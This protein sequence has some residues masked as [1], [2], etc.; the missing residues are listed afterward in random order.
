MEYGIKLCNDEV[1]DDNYIKHVGYEQNNVCIKAYFNKGTV[2]MI[3]KKI[4][5]LLKGVAEDNRPIIVPDK[6]ICSVM[7]DIYDSYRPPTGDIYS[8]YN[9]P[10]GID[11]DNYV[12]SMIEQ[13]I[14]V[15]TSDVRN[16]LGMEQ[17][18]K[19][20]TIW[21]T[22]YGDFNKHGLQQHPEIKI[23]KR[24][25]QHMAFNMNY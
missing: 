7:S 5:E 9:I 25:P 18:N 22:L 2:K 3:S 13:V 21:T 6:T 10:S 20:L 15:I 8:R 4:T 19:K 1:C 11:S 23:R 12:K 16:N 17:N 24:H 14:E